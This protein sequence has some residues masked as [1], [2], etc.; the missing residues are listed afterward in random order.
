MPKLVEGMQLISAT[1]FDFPLYRH[2]EEQDK[3]GGAWTGNAKNVVPSNTP[4]NA[5]TTTPQ[6]AA[7]FPGQSVPPQ[8]ASLPPSWGVPQTNNNK[9]LPL[10]E[11]QEQELQM[12]NISLAAEQQRR[13]EQQRFEQQQRVEQQILEQQRVEQQR[14]L[15]QQQEQQH[16][17]EK[18]TDNASTAWKNQQ[19]AKS[20]TQNLRQIQEEELVCCFVC[21]AATLIYLFIPAATE[22]GE[23]DST[24]SATA[25]CTCEARS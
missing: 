16:P 22:E 20:N 23:G 3:K 2:G 4:T 5:A 7:T 10:K 8:P 9:G 13:L 18:D 17:Q 6:N 1:F 15:E 12:H 11:I 14:A 21:R 25:I 19:R 24:D